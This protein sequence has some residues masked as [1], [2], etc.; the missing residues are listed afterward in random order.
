MTQAGAIHRALAGDWLRVT[1][2]R[3]RL[4]WATLRRYHVAVI[5]GYAPVRF[6]AAELRALDRFVSEGGGLLLAASTPSF[7][8]ETD[9]PAA[10][11]PQDAVAELFGYR[12]LASFEAAGP[13]AEDR[14]FRVG[15]PHERAVGRPE[16]LETLGLTDFGP[17]PPM[18]RQWAPVQPPA[19]AEAVLVHEGTGEALAAAGNHGAGRVFVVGASTV[20]GFNVLSHL[21]PVVRWLAGEAVDRRGVTWRRRSGRGRRSGASGS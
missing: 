18:V 8:L 17:H 12:F 13:V 15:Y 9:R 21:R 19:H 1:V 3:Q 11:M 4:T 5:S 7:E 10:E 20:D 6:S 14:D 16:G 2:S